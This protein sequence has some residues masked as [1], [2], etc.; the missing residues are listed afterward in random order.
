MFEGKQMRSSRRQFRAAIRQL[1]DDLK[2]ARKWRLH[3]RGLLC[4]F[5]VSMPIMGLFYYFGRPDLARP[6]FVSVTALGFVIAVKWQLRE[7]AWFWIMMSFFVG[8]HVLLVLSITWSTEW[9]PAVVST[10]TATIDIYALL[11]VVSVV[12]QF[13]ERPTIPEG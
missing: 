5:I 4:L 2:R 8:L 1:H 11:A 3:W 12:E 6:T 7:R 9:I 13:A 10:G